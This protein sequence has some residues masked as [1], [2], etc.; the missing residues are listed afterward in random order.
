MGQDKPGRDISAELDKLNPH[1]WGDD[2][3]SPVATVFKFTAGRPKSSWQQ[4]RVIK[5]L[6]EM[7]PDGRLPRPK[8]L[9]ARLAKRD[10]KLKS[11]D[12]KTLRR[13]LDAIR[14]GRL[15]GMRHNPTNSE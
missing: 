7:Y 15:V 4:Q 6:R 14:R 8:L 2:P 1:R 3:V 12:W 11:L 13:A 9:L 5:H 10:P